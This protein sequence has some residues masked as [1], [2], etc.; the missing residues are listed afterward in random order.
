M[1]FAGWPARSW[2]DKAP[3]ASPGVKAQPPDGE[4]V[5][6]STHFRGAAEPHEVG[7]ALCLVD[8]I[9]GVGQSETDAMNMISQPPVILAKKRDGPV[10]DLR[11][12][13]MPAEQLEVLLKLLSDALALMHYDSERASTR[14]SQ[15]IEL[16]QPATAALPRRTCRNGGLTGWQ[17]QRLDSFI[18]QHL[19]NPIRTPQLAAILNLSVS[20]FSHAFKQALGV[21]PLAYVARRRIESARKVMLSSPSSLTEI[22]LGHGFCDQSHF[23]RTFRRETGLSPKMWRRVFGQDRSRACPGINSDP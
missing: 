11:F 21:A 6:L 5:K 23:S 13:A 12:A 8:N 1:I 18:D 17:I 9:I 3:K 7:F 2:R 10:T 14:L 4:A 16:L 19:D 22:A 20:H 15:A